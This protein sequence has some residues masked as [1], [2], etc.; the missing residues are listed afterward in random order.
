VST[1]LSGFVREH[2]GRLEELAAE[3]VR[4][5]SE[6]RPPVGAERACQEWIAARLGG[7]A[8]EV[9]LYGLDEVPGLKQHPLF[10]PGRD[11]AGRPNVGARLRGAGGG[12]SLLLSGHVDT[13]PRGEA[14]WTQEPFEGASSDGRLYGR[15]ALDMKAGVATALFVAE[16]L[17]ELKVRLK[18]DLLIESVVDEEFGGVNGTLAGRLRG[19]NADAAVIGEPSG[20]RICPAQRGGRLA[21]LTFRAAGDIFAD[22]QAPAGVIEQARCFL[23]ELPRFAEIRQRRAPSHPL[24][25]HLTER[26]PV[27]VTRISTAPWGTSEPITVPLACRVEVYW[28][29][30]PGESQEDVEGDFRAWLDGAIAAHPKLFAVRPEVEY[31]IRWLPGS[32]LSPADPLVTE[33]AACARE[34]LGCPPPIQGIEAPCD[35]FVFHQAFSTPAV[36]WGPR[37]ANAHAPDEYVELDSLA[38]A[39]EVLLRFVCQWCG[40]AA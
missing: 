9:D 26:A 34:T 1:D 6:N 27:S 19:L 12:R 28:Q 30:V 4:M 21:H 14:A 22:E 35:M 25:A 3:L 16:A 24:Y 39:A 17:A 33:L 10:W 23:N 18:G 38:A 15:G 37:G 8:W 2:R 11:Y 31:P 13:V 7:L 20:L 32:A 40:V 5:P 36:L 29:A